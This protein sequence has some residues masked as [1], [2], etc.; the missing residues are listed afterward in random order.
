MRT[1]NRS[2]SA[3]GSANVP[4]SSTG[5]SRREDQERVGQRAA[6]A[7]GRHLP[8][9]HRLEEGRLRPRRGAV[10]LVDEQN[11]RE[12]RAGDEPERARLVDRGAGDVAG[13]QVRRPLDAGKRE[14]QG[15]RE[16]ARQERLADAGHVLDQGVAVG[17][18]RDGE[19]PQRLGFADDCVRDRARQVGPEPAAGVRVGPGSVIRAPWLRWR[20]R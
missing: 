20:L 4:S 5:F 18:H 19:Q 13:Q 17:Q 15:S 10:D 11:I 3:S 1:R 2:S 6:F 8:L 7:L 14:A 12:D 16:R 9:L